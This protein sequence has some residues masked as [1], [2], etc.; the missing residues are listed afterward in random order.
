MR[1]PLLAGDIV[2]MSGGASYL[3]QRAWLRRTLARPEVAEALRLASPS[4]H[5]EIDIWRASPDG[6]RGRSIEQALTRYVARMATRATPF[7][8]FAGV[9]WGEVRDTQR[10]TELYFIQGASAQRRTRVDSEVLTDILHIFAGRSDVQGKLRYVPNSTIAGLA[11]QITFLQQRSTHADR[12]SRRVLVPAAMTASEAVSAALVFARG[13]VTLEDLA[14]ALLRHDPRHAESDVH[15]FCKHLVEAQ[16][17]VA[18]FG[19]R[20]TDS[21]PLRTAIAELRAMGCLDAADA[22]QTLEKSLQ[23]LD[24]QGVGASHRAYAAV[25]EVIAGLLSESDGAP[26]RAG[27]GGAGP[28]KLDERALQVDVASGATGHVGSSVI[29]EVEKVTRILH[30]VMPTRVDPALASFRAGFLRRFGQREVPLVLA[31]D[32]E[33]GVGFGPAQRPHAGLAS[34]LPLSPRV[35]STPW[36]AKHSVLLRRI[37]DV[38]MRDELELI[39]TEEDLLALTEV[40]DESLPDAFG[41]HVRLAAATTGSGCS[42][43]FQVFLEK[44]Q[45]PSGARRLGRF[46]RLSP[47]LEV[48]VREHIEAEQALRPDALLAEIVHL[49]TPRDGNVVGR[50][51]LRAHEIAY[52]GR[53]SAHGEQ[54]LLEDLVVTVT[55]E[56]VVLRCARRNRQVLPRLSAAHSPTGGLSLYRFLLALQ[57][58]GSEGAQW[59]WGPLEDAPFLPRV[60]IGRT[61]VSRARWN[62]EAREV[63]AI[64]ALRAD[65]AAAFAAIQALRQQRKLPRHIVMAEAD[66]ELFVDL[67]HALMV[68][69]LVGAIKRG[70]SAVL[71]EA[72]PRPD[73][74]VVSGPDGTH[75]AELTLLFTREQKNGPPRAPSP[76]PLV[77]PAGCIAAEPG[78]NGSLAGGGVAVASMSSR[79]R[80]LCVELNGNRLAIRNGVQMLAKAVAKVSSE[81]EGEGAWWFEWRATPEP[82]LLFCA[83]TT[84]SSIDALMAALRKVVAPFIQDGLLSRLRFD[85]QDGNEHPAWANERAQQ[86]LHQVAFRDAQAVLLGWEADGMHPP[87]PFALRSAHLLLRSLKLSDQQY[88]EILARR[89]ET[90]QKTLNPAGP[91]LGKLGHLYREHLP[92]I[93]TV[94][95]AGEGRATPSSMALSRRSEAIARSV[96]MEEMFDGTHAAEASYLFCEAVLTSHF[97]RAF[98]TSA[99]LNELILLHFLRRQHRRQAA[100]SGAIS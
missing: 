99:R 43:G 40:S 61:V 69:A 2:M 73:G 4:L 35:E 23:E 18:D 51:A 24:E 31:L 65:R 55:D 1:T 62:I 64:V 59:S 33:L 12:G 80:V 20:A 19:L 8:L 11:G 39:L 5:E 9:A 28:R 13:G 3:E 36:L 54:V 90:L 79:P 48:L 58:Q 70:A 96:N 41:A 17:L 49:G 85:F 67:D 29:H 83:E 89:I 25:L 94:L 44:M 81:G 7:G 30:R 16:L 21:D 15:V 32:E 27:S 95:G 82:R 71:L 93:S 14:R 97:N 10:T 74:F 57:Q 92:E 38:T 60:R 42:G 100:L 87:W 84:D 66:N 45:G 76:S 86:A 98:D 50:P 53:G 78:G 52:G 6:E 91:I 47:D 34:S 63:D 56:R 88:A 46:C 26:A 77:R 72:F 22:L 75:A 37:Q 68:D